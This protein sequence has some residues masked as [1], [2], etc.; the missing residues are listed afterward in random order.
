LITHR[1]EIDERRSRSSVKSLDRRELTEDRSVI[2]VYSTQGDAPWRIAVNDFDFSCLGERKSLTA[3]DN[4][5]VLIKILMAGG[6]AEMNNAYD[7]LKTVLAHVW[8]LQN[9]TSEGRS[10]R[11]RAGRNEISTVTASDNETQFN[12]Y[13]RLVWRV[14][15]SETQQPD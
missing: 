7:R 11:P 9:T 2:D 1:L 15:L 10:R 8:P 6:Q 14:K 13:S 5:T 12:K 3:F 4:A